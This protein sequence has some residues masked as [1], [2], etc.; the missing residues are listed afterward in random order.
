MAHRL[1]CSLSSSPPHPT[2][3]RPAARAEQVV[4]CRS[5]E[6]QCTG[7]VPI[8]AVDKSDGCQV[9]LC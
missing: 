5:V 1:A 6:V 2:Q 8:V 4:N 9:R 3:P 7:Q